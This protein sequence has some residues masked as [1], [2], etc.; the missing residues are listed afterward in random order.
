MRVF[1]LH[2]NVTTILE[3]FVVLMYDRTSE[4]HKVNHARQV[5]FSRGNRQLENIP[6]TLA[7]LEQHILRATYLCRFIWGQCL[8]KKLIFPPQNSGDG[9]KTV[10]TP[11]DYIAPSSEFM[12]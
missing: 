4:S 1:P 5:L 10:Q 11:L 6:L 8:E 2:E 3:R 7:A 12:L 9:R